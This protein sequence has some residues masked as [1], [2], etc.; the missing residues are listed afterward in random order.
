MGT[1]VQEYQGQVQPL[2][3]ARWV[4]LTS[5]TTQPFFSIEETDPNTGRFRMNGDVPNGTYTLSTGPS[6]QGPWTV[7]DAAYV[8]ASNPA[9]VLGGSVTLPAAGATTTGGPFSAPLQD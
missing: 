7:E 3:P 1:I 6:K 4:R 5:T 8:V 2:S 9:T